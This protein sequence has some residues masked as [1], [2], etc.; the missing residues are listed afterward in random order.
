[1]DASGP[2]LSSESQLKL[3]AELFRSSA[4]EN[5][6]V[7]VE[8]VIGGAREKIA[9][10]QAQLPAS[11][12]QYAGDWELKMRTSQVEPFFLGHT[13]PTF[14]VK[15]GGKF[16]FEPA[17][18][19]F[20]L[21]GS[22]QAQL[23]RLEAINPA[24]RA[25]GPVKVDATF[26][27]GQQ[28]DVLQLAQLKAL[29]TGTTPLLEAHTTAPIRYDVRKHQ[30]LTA[31]ARGAE[32]PARDAHRCARGLGP[33]FRLP[34]PIFL[35]AFSRAISTWHRSPEPSRPSRCGASCRRAS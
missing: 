22:V 19:S 35:A 26:D 11:A 20:S 21:Q 4:G 31:P 33:A 23:S 32:P 34:V 28:E 24:W 12:R 13:L 3:G 29:V 7:T 27:G 16:A 30:L 25:F 14:D 17:G 1:M 10:F 6:E 2:A 15:G 5:Y 9:K 18:S 8:T